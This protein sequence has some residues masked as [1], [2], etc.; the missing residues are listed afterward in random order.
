MSVEVALAVL[1][2]D[3]TVT[4][5]VGSGSSAKISPLIKSQNLAAPAV[6][7]QRVNVDPQNHLRGHANLDDVRVQ[8]DAWAEKYADARALATACRNAM[9]TAGHLMISEVDNTD[10]DVDPLL[11]RITQD[12]RVWV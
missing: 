10:M 3:S 8:L 9:Q 1:K 11:Y 12:F 2:A 4:A 6:T 7:L 5:I